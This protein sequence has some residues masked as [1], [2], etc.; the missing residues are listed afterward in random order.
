MLKTLSTKEKLL[1]FPQ[2]LQKPSSS[3]KGFKGKP[4]PSYRHFLIPLQQTAFWKLGD[5]RRNCS[6]WAISAFVTM[7]STPF[8]YCTF[9]RREFPFFFWYIFKGDCCRLF[10][11][12]NGVNTQLYLQGSSIRGRKVTEAVICLMTALIS[13]FISFS[14]LAF[15]L[16]EKQIK[17]HKMMN[18]Q[19]WTTKLKAKVNF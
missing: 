4:F 10:V 8:N 18:V 6:K 19:R 7:F 5:K 17:R 15:G 14:G 9:I 13:S 1:L 12:W 11:C 2:C 16:L 3:G